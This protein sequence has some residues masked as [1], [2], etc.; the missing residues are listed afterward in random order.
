MLPTEAQLP[1]L[2]AHYTSPLTRRRLLS[3]LQLRNSKETLQLEKQHHSQNVEQMKASLTRLENDKRDL[4]L[5]VARLSKEVSA[6]GCVRPYGGL[7]WVAPL[8]RGL[9]PTSHDCATVNSGR[10]QPGGCKGG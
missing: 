1:P 5:E 10:V 9:V 4:I 3:L 6:C 2:T 7:L 8:T